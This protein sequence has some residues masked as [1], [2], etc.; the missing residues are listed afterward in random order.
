MKFQKI[1]IENFETKL[2]DLKLPFDTTPI[3]QAVEFAKESHFGQM[4]ESGEPY[5][6]HCLGCCYILAEMKMDTSL[7][8]AGILHDV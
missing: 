4:R 1:T 8:V 6:N 3:F 7:L 5:I 2:N